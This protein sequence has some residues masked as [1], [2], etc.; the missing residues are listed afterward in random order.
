LTWTKLTQAVN[1]QSWSASKKAQFNANGTTFG[2]N[3]LMPIAE[4]GGELVLQNVFATRG[5]NF[6]F[7]QV[8]CKAGNRD[9]LGQTYQ[10][11]SALGFRIART[12]PE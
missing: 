8:S 2:V 6:R 7:P 3:H 4:Y 11:S 1:A 12:L 5:G 10:G 9:Y